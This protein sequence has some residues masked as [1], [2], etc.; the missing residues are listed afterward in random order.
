MAAIHTV[1]LLNNV[2]LTTLNVNR[3]ENLLLLNASN[4]KECLVDR[5]TVRVTERVMHIV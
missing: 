2:R 5:K 4:Q 1:A 3:Y